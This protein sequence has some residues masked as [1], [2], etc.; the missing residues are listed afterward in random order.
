MLRN[1]T[2]ERTIMQFV[3]D[4]CSSGDWQIKFY[5]TKVADVKADPDAEPDERF[6]YEGAARDFISDMRLR[7]PDVADVLDEMLMA[8]ADNIR[9]DF[10]AKSME[11]G[12]LI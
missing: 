8:A 2:Y 5:I 9:C 6:T 10:A 11:I 7:D 3:L 4:E 1:K 12:I